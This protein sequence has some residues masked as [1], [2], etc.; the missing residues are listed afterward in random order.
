MAI[1]KM[2]GIAISNG[3]YVFWKDNEPDIDG[4]NAPEA[5]AIDTISVDSISNSSSIITNWTS[6]TTNWS[7]STGTPPNIGNGN[8]YSLW[9]RIGD[10]IEIK[11]TIE[12]GSTTVI[13]SGNNTWNLSIPTGLLIDTG[14][15]I[16][17][18]VVSNVIGNGIANDSSNGYFAYQIYTTINGNLI[19]LLHGNGYNVSNGGPIPWSTG[20]I[21][22]INATLPIIGFDV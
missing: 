10:S 16:G 5:V 6:Y 2:R 21:I 18:T 8:I 4:S 22:T 1:F 15:T 11:I 9:R 14:K 12:I 20:D 19:S 13:G 17:T 7:T 3:N